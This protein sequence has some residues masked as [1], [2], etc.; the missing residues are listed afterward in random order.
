L[1]NIEAYVAVDNQSAA[2]E[3]IDHLRERA[4]L[5]EIE[6]LLGKQ[7]VAS[8]HRELV[9]TRYPYTIIYR[10]RGS[11]VIISRVLHQRRKFP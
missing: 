1:L 9:L 7:R 4:L 8:P 6:P 11:R 5:L 3:V 10:T 2:D